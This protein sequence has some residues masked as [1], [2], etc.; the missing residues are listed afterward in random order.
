MNYRIDLILFLVMFSFYA[1]GRLC[2]VI[3][4]APGYLKLYYKEN[5]TKIQGL[6]NCLNV[7]LRK[8][9]R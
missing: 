2:C 3:V 8:Y 9:V 5:R 6:R 4:E 1:A 7:Y